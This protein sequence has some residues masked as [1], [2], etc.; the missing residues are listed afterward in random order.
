[1]TQPNLEEMSSPKRLDHM[2][3]MATEPQGDILSTQYFVVRN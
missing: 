3:E 2:T 1:M